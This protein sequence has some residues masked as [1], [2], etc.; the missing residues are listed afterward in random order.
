MIPLLDYNHHD[1]HA[2]EV[3]RKAKPSDCEASK[4]RGK[5]RID[6]KR[7]EM[8]NV[9]KA[10]INSDDRVQHRAGAGEVSAIGFPGT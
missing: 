4:S 8:S 9:E 1:P 3:P 2:K 6:R 5:K 10:M 7:G